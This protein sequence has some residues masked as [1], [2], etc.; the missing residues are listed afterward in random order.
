MKKTLEIKSPHQALHEQATA[1]FKLA[2]D[3]VMEEH[4]QKNL[5]IYALRDGKVVDI[6]PEMKTKLSRN[7]KKRNGKRKAA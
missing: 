2:I 3:K 1:A 6:L 7:G 5:P 4:V